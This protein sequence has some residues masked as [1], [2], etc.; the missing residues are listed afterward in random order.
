MRSQYPILFVGQLKNRVKIPH[1][2]YTPRAVVLKVGLVL[3]KHSSKKCRGDG[4]CFK[5]Q[6]LLCCW[7][8]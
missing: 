3:L 8:Y 4:G 6:Q 5:D 2:K 7:L 1:H